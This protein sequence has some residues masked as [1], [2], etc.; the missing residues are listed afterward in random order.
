METRY[1]AWLPASAPEAVAKKLD[2]LLLSALS[3]PAVAERL[4]GAG[5]EPTTTMGAAD[6]RKRLIAERDTWQKVIR[7]NGIKP[8]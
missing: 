6:S 3:D 2:G 5:L 1:F 7:E 4:R 8:E